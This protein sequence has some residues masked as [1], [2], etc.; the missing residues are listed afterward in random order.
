MGYLWVALAA[1]DGAT[2]YAEAKVDGSACE[3]GK[4]IAGRA[5]GCAA[6]GWCLGWLGGVPWHGRS[7]VVM[8]IGNESSL[9]VRVLSGSNGVWLGGWAA[10][11]ARMVRAAAA[12]VWGRR[13]WWTAASLVGLCVQ[14]ICVQFGQLFRPG[15]V[16]LRP[17]GWACGS[18]GS[19]CC[20][21]WMVAPLV[22]LYGLIGQQFST[23][24]ASLGGSGARWMGQQLSFFELQLPWLVAGAAGGWWYLWWGCTG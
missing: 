19:G 1:W 23:F 14:W 9:H 24:Q 10:R 4:L 17:G 7:I 3:E 18:G 6:A 2:S 21:R 20:C 16:G 15:W 5:D 22:G 13:C 8:A 11:V 12:S